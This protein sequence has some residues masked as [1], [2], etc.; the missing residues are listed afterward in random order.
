MKLYAIYD[1]DGKLV[2]PAW[3]SDGNVCAE[4]WGAWSLAGFAGDSAIKRAKRQGY[5]CEEVE[6]VKV[7]R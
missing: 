5:T 6:I 1:K 2:R 3:R 7:K 4:K